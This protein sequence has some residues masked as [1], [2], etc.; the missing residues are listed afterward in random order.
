M[1]RSRVDVSLS[2]QVPA[3][4]NPTRKPPR[5]PKSTLKLRCFYAPAAKLAGDRE[6]SPSRAQDRAAEPTQ[7]KSQHTGE[8]PCDRQMVFKT[9]EAWQPHAG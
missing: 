1:M 8:I 9:G 4:W 2:A 6:P 3:L 7:A 5:G